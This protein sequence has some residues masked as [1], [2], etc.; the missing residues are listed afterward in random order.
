MLLPLRRGSGCRVKVGSRSWSR[1]PPCWGFI[2][3]PGSPASRLAL[4]SDNLIPGPP[5]AGQVKAKM[6]RG[7][8]R[9]PQKAEDR[10]SSCAGEWPAE[11]ENSIA[12]PGSTRRSGGQ[13]LGAGERQG[14]LAGGAER[15]RPGTQAA[16]R[17][18]DE[19]SQEVGFVAVLAGGARSFRR[20]PAPGK[21]L[22]L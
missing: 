2:E 18:E 12:S 20:H 7:E 13:R 1:A 10:R 21:D 22:G 6:D 14:S 4:P 11:M 5:P 16:R 3:I 17:S 15:R 8:G 9:T 19:E